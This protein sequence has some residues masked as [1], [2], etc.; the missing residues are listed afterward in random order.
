MSRTVRVFDHL[1]GHEWEGDRGAANTGQN[2]HLIAHGAQPALQRR[3]LVQQ[4]VRHKV[5]AL[6][7]VARHAA[8]RHAHGRPADDVFQ[9]QQ[10]T[11]RLHVVVV[12][13]AAATAD[14]RRVQQAR[15]RG[16]LHLQDAGAKRAPAGHERRE[17]ARGGDG[18]RH[19]AQAQDGV[20]DVLG[21][22]VA[23][24][25]DGD[26]VHAGVQRL[27]R[28]DVVAV[29]LHQVRHVERRPRAHAL[30]L[31]HAL[32]DGTHTHARNDMKPQQRTQQKA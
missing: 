27:Q 9:V 7:V 11:R 1:H 20:G 13:V 16:R 24:D 21:G 30:V 19:A 6:Q 2:P 15:G 32:V 28:H 17:D 18:Q 31:V 26:A 5:A 22:H 25:E 3:S 8:H 14:P 4:Q 23:N 10:R 12:G 29:A